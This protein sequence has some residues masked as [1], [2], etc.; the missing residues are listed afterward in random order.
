[1]EAMVQTGD[2]DGEGASATKVMVLEQPCPTPASSSPT[3]RLVLQQCM[4]AQL[5]VQPPMEGAHP[6]FV[7]IQRGLI[8]YVCFL[9][10][11]TKAQVEKIAKMAL[12][13]RL[14]E[15]DNGKL[16][17]VFDLPGDILIIPQATLGGTLK[18][19][20]MQYHK[21]IAKEEGQQLYAE[22]VSIFQKVYERS[23]KCA[24]AGTVVRFGTYGNRQVFSCQ[25]NGPYTHLIEI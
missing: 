15:G 23:E 13:V 12:S 16:V 14:S 5:M 3:I 1:M 20:V 18:G 8:I 11:A 6:Q 19:K 17:S 4:S 7:E 24:A 9:R 22:F 10:G 2:V 21:N 25:T